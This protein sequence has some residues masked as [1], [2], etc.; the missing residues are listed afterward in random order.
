MRKITLFLIF[1]MVIITVQA[2][3]TLT[4]IK[5]D[6][7][8]TSDGFPSS[9]SIA[10]SAVWTPSYTGGFWNNFFNN[11]ANVPK[12]DISSIETTGAHG[13]A[14]CLKISVGANSVAATT[15][16]LRSLTNSIAAPGAW[17]KQVLTFWAKTDAATSG[18][19]LLKGS[20][21]TVTDQW[22]KFILTNSYSTGLT[23]TIITIDLINSTSTPAAPSAGY[24][25]YF[26]DFNY[27]STPATTSNAATGVNSTGF[28]AEWTAVSGATSYILTVEKSD[29][30]TTPVWTAISGSPFTET[31]SSK[32]LS[33]LVTSSNYRYKIV[34]TDGEY[35]SQAS[36]Y[37]YVTTSPTTGI[38]TTYIPGLYTQNR[39]IF[40]PASEGTS[41]KVFNQLGQCVAKTVSKGGINELVVKI[42]G[43]YI[44][45]SDNNSQKVI[46]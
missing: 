16:R 31:G 32:V 33:D 30:G 9:F 2:Q 14:Q 20:T 44:V 18:I 37:I 34:A 15:L 21:K 8:E 41:I 13:G 26:D 5:T 1:S 40:V 19:A 24:N 3:L 29:G 23:A 28:T 4:T 17:D 25:V 27:A 43:L 46:L 11:S 45:K 7:F 39:T 10:N 38:S 42:P 12:G 6:G 22:Q 35:F 36:S